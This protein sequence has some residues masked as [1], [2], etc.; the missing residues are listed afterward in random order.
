MKQ[1]PKSIQVTNILFMICLLLALLIIGREFLYPI[2]LAILFAYL[3]FPLA[4]L[5]EKWR[6]PRVLAILSSIIL[7][8]AVI[9]GAMYFFYQQL[10]VFLNDFPELKEQAYS[11]LD[12]LQRKIDLVTENNNEQRWWLRERIGELINNSGNLFNTIFSAT[13]GTAVKMGLQPVFVFFMLYYRERFKKFIYIVFGEHSYGKV[14]QILGEVSEVT[15]NYISGVFIVVFILCFLNSF[16]LMIVGVEYAVMF[17]ILSAVMNFIPY[18]GTLIG[19]IFPLAYTL[20]SDEPANAVGVVILF[21]II[22]FTE[23]NI[24][25]PNITGGRVAINPF[26]TILVIIAGGMVWGIPGMF[27]SVP[28]AGMAKVVCSHI[29]GLRPIAF[30]ISRNKGSQLRNGWKIIKGWFAGRRKA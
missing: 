4:A 26:F 6:F 9:G 7:G 25:T 8:M 10:K 13:T 27:M 24:L 19:A 18:F 30:L 14:R 20:V 16:G 3:L 29:P 2:F 5:L 28:Y 23:N 12:A 21:M 1:L 15:K 22:Q 11:N 17:G